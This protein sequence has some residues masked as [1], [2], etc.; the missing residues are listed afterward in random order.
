MIRETVNH[1]MECTF[2]VRIPR[3]ED[4]FPFPRGTG[5]FI[6]ED[7]YFITANHVIEDVKDFSRVS[8][9][10][11]PVMPKDSAILQ[12]ISLIEKWA[13]FD[14]ALLNIDIELNKKNA[15]LV[16]RSKFPYLKINFTEQM[17]GTPVY[18]YGFPL[19]GIDKK[20]SLGHA[21]M[22]TDVFSPRV[23]SVI[24]S[25]KYDYIFPGRGKSETKLYAI[26]KAL[27]YG[28]SGGPIVLTESG[29]VF[30]VCVR[31]QPTSIKQLH[32]PQGIPIMLPSNYGIISS[33][34][35]IKS[36]LIENEI[37]R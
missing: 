2:A 33:L 25:C 1:T 17:E 8:I 36:Y 22:F 32:L 16:K 34:S 12:H 4:N 13:K 3:K 18:S 10:Q 24:I 28:N 35:N 27:D 20:I 29:E 19:S 9:Y 15:Y 5:F 21:K 31:F 7:G 11:P 37:I 30:A 14:L 26:D 6:S 23:T